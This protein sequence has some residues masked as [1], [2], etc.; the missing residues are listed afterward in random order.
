MKR[1]VILLVLLAVFAGCNS[2]TDGSQTS[3]ADLKAIEKIVQKQLDVNSG[4]KGLKVQV[5]ELTNLKDILPGYAYA[6][7][8]VYDNKSK[9]I[10]TQRVITD[11]K[12]I[13]KDVINAET[14]SS[15]Q[16]DLEFDYAAVEVI[17][18]DNLT[19]AG[20]KKDAKNVIVEITDFQCTYCK[21]AHLL[22]K[23]ELKNK[24]DYAL[25]IVHL[26]LDMHPNAQ[27]MAQ[28]FEAGAK[29]GFNFKNNLLE[30]D[31][32]KVLE[33]KMKDLQNNGTQLNQEVLS[34]L[35]NEVNEQIINEYASKTDN[36]EKFKELV[37]SD[38]I[39]DKVEQ[40]KKLAASLKISGTPAFYINGK[41]ISGYNEGLLLKA[42]K[43]IK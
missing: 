10:D 25:Y 31:Y 7:I 4:D 43:N 22:L 39:K 12:Y 5:V 37:N 19:L 23:E 14:L 38:E 42:L 27:L 3:G 28:V 40:S 20:G 33:S 17:D 35:V 29:M 13:V 21:K 36:P 41:A 9:V 16:D 18:T 1:I 32:I 26:P 34:S 6:E 2:K 11:G 8:R 24:S 30:T 15:I